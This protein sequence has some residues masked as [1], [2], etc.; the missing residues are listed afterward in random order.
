MKELDSHGIRT[1]AVPWAQAQ[2]AWPMPRM[3][4]SWGSI[5]SLGWVG[6]VQSQNDFWGAKIEQ[7]QSRSRSHRGKGMNWLNGFSK[8]SRTWIGLKWWYQTLNHG[9][10][11]GW[12]PKQIRSDPGGDWQCGEFRQSKHMNDCYELMGLR[13]I[14]IYI[15]YVYIYIMGY[16]GYMVVMG[17][18]LQHSSIFFDQFL[19]FW[20]HLPKKPLDP[21]AVWVGLGWSR[22]NHTSIFSYISPICFPYV[23]S[24]FPFLSRYFQ[25]WCFS[26]QVQAGVHKPTGM[27]VA[28]KTVPSSGSPGAWENEHF[29]SWKITIFSR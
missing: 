6:H 7:I 21:L 26:P 19:T 23:P 9:E 24:I 25:V 1:A 8:S 18:F 17:S 12:R 11:H 13:Y 2:V 16:M 15:L 10:D 4:M 28:I 14:Y 29:A 3:G 22:K 20:Y 5:K 27:R